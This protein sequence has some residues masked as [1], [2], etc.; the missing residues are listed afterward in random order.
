MFN[1]IKNRSVVTQVL[2]AFMCLAALWF[3][4]FHTMLN[5]LVEN[6]LRMQ[7]KTVINNVISLGDYV[8]IHG[9]RS[10]FK[11]DPNYRGNCLERV[12]T[13]DGNTFCGKNPAL[14]QRE[15]S[16]QVRKNNLPVTFRM[17]SQNPMNQEINRPDS[18][19]TFALAE[20][21]RNISLGIK[22][23]AI[24]KNNNG[25]YEYIEPIYHTT[26]CIACHGDPEK[27]PRSIQE[28]YGKVNG[29]GFKAGDLAGGISVK[30][31]YD[32][33]SML[34][35]IV[36]SHSLGVLIGSALLFMLCIYLIIRKLSQVIIKIENYK[37]GTPI[38]IDTREIPE[39]TNNEILRMI[40]GISKLAQLIEFSNGQLDSANR[41]LEET[42]QQL[43]QANSGSSNSGN[44]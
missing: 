44:Q 27:A 36:D 1:I 23:N 32:M 25:V 34:R 26:G 18:F 20:I 35:D 14:V 13:I 5:N 10:W 22:D 40:K 7:A 29:F 41:K 4:G 6:Q 15:F 19:E 17:T 12:E 31:S 38:G 43:K 2:L 39:K 16:D 3:Y 11:V 8:A 21:A 33:K 37:R 30:I 24:S 28:L 9:G 42:R